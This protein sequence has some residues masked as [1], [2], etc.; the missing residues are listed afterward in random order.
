MIL[1]TIAEHTVCLD[2]LPENAKILDLGCRGFEFTKYFAE[3]PYANNKVIPVDIDALQVTDYPY[4]QFAVTDYCGTAGIIHGADAQ[5]TKI[6]PGGEGVPA[7]TLEKLME[8]CNV[9]FFDLIKIDVEGSE[10][11]IIMSLTK[12]P[13]TQISWEAHLHT[14]AYGLSE[15]AMMEAKLMSL[16]YKAVKN[17][18][19]EAHGAGK[20]AWD[21][22]FVLE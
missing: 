6:E 14:N 5:A 4:Y 21:N 10:K 7:I 19:Y 2:L 18:I 12:A 17:D 11:E 16:G 22:L 20:N 13:A 1:T 8:L 3:R 15:L 9:P